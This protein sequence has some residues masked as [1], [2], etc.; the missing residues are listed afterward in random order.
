MENVIEISG[1][2]KNYKGF[3][4]KDVSLTLPRGNVYG[5]VGENGAGKTTLLKS[6]L[7]IVKPDSGDIKVFGKNP[8]EFANE[9]KEKIGVVFDIPPFPP[10]LSAT[11]LDKVFR[12]VFKTW[13]SNIYFQY[14]DR[15]G[16][17]K[18]KKLKSY[19]R[20]M[21]MRLAIAVALAHSPE[22]LVL[23]EPT[24]GLDPVVRNE[25]LEIFREFMIDENHSIIISTHITC[26]LDQL[27]DY[28]CFMDN[29]RVILSDDR[30]SIFDGFRIVKCTAEQLSDIDREDI[31]AVRE[32]RFSIDVMVRNP[33]KY[34]HLPS[35]R[36]AID[37]ILVYLKLAERGAKK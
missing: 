30:D 2:N 17:P 26:D 13:D 27:A 12:G 20:G 10:S 25:L 14:I 16:L 29:G 8:A 34:S 3:T 11:Q 23:D 37:E 32:S 9:D 35:D 22:L 21:G 28:L 6:I 5:L 7:G 31:V 33:E 1:L 18:D 24:G 15:F 36:P 4:M 19:S